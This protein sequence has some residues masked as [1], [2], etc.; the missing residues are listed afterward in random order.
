MPHATMFDYSPLDNTERVRRYEIEIST[1]DIDEATRKAKN[2][3]LPGEAM[4]RVG[5]KEINCSPEEYSAALQLGYGGIA[6]HSNNG[7]R[8]LVFPLAA[9]RRSAEKLLEEECF[10]RD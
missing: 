9:N 5:H 2:V 4:V 8:T 6:L 10:E 1:D 7:T 3:A